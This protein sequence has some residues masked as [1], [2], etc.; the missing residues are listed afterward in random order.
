MTDYK[1]IADIVIK[2][3]DAILERKRRRAITVK[4]VSLSA[5][6]LCA[7]GI[8]GLGVWRNDSIKNAVRKDIPSQSSESIISETT[9]TASETI[10]TATNNS[11]IVNTTANIDNSAVITTTPNN[12]V[13]PPTNTNSTTTTVKNGIHT[14]QTA[15]SIVTNVVSSTKESSSATTTVHTSASIVT[16]TVKPPHDRTT[17]SASDT[18]TVTTT[19]LPQDVYCFN[20]SFLDDTTFEKIDNVNATLIQQKIEWVDNE[21][22]KDIGEGI[23]VGEWTSSDK[24]PYVA[25]FTKDNTSE[26][27][28]TVIADTLPPGYSY[29]GKNS[30]E[31]GISGYF[32]GERNV[33]ILLTKEEVSAS[34]TPLEGIY[35]LKLKVWDFATNTTIENL[36]C[37][38]Y[39]I[40]TGEVVAKWNTTDTEELY[41]ENLR[42]SFDKPDSYNGNITYAIRITNLP[43]NYRFYYGK[44]RVMYG[45]CGFGL[46]E[47]ENGTELDCIAYL[48]DVNKSSPK[49][50]Y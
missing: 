37:E 38:L 22:T 10:T 49:Y 27:R 48:E 9:S 13:I 19:T 46:E 14:E 16:S 4:R 35:S 8:V 21:H 42:Y 43:E 47:F 6:G 17:T 50:S 33:D 5:S 40:Q 25:K 41:I 1:Q 28:Y 24:N 3:G 2:E 29:Y 7:A 45:I 30:V 32:E 34:S 20:I 18:V 31:Q 44:S 23:K 15:S 36:D 39:C 12:K 11:D 26:Y